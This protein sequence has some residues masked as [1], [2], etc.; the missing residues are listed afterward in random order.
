[1]RKLKL[2]ELL[3][4][5]PQNFDAEINSVL[6]KYRY[7]K[8]PGTGEE[9]QTTGDKHNDESNNRDN[10]R[11]LRSGRLYNVN[12]E[13]LSENTAKEAEVAYWRDERVY[14]REQGITLRSILIA[15]SAAE[16]EIKWE[17]DLEEKYE[18]VGTKNAQEF[19]EHSDEVEKRKYK[20]NKTSRFSSE[21]EGTMI[22]RMKRTGNERPGAR[23]KFK[24]IIIHF[25]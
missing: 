15:H 1:M 24:E 7:K 20:R 22:V 8:G 25:Y 10:K 3:T 12:V 9:E 21:K 19:T 18:I 16:R 2:D 11:K 5:L 23:V 13:I 4:L 17:R 6:D 14:K